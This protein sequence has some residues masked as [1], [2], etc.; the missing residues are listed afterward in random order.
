MLVQLFRALP[1]L[2]LLCSAVMVLG[3]FL[4]AH[5]AP[6]VRRVAFFIA[7]LVMGAGIAT[8]LVACS[9]AERCAAARGASVA[10]AVL[11]EV[12][13]R[14][15]DGPI[16]GSSGGESAAVPDDMTAEEHRAALDALEAAAAEL[17][18]ATPDAGE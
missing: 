11:A 10:A 8:G 16:V 5:A 4:V 15:C 12:A 18:N 13:E 7:R 6:S 2:L 17:R 1:L 9:P 3:A 14:A